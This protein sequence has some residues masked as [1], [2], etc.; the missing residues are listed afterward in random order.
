MARSRTLQK[1][2]DSHL[3]KWT[4]AI[5]WDSCKRSVKKTI[6]TSANFDKVALSLS[7]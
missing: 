2:I 5:L 1:A 7:R 4:Y 3:V 6:D